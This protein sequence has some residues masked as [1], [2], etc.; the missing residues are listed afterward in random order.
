MLNHNSELLDEATMLGFAVEVRRKLTSQHTFVPLRGDGVVERSF[1]WM[2][3]LC[4]RL[5]LP[6]TPLSP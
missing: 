1:G 6:T 2:Q 3:L 5:A 4:L